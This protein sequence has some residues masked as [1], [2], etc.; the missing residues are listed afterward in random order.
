VSSRNRLRIRTSNGGVERRDGLD[1][2]LDPA[3]RQE[4]EAPV[5]VAR[6]CDWPRRRPCSSTSTVC[7]DRPLI[8]RCWVQSDGGAGRRA[9]EDDQG[10]EIGPGP[11]GMKLVGT[12]ELDLGWA[13]RAP[14]CQARP[15]GRSTAS[16][17]SAR[18]DTRSTTPSQFPP[19]GGQT[20]YT[21]GRAP[22]ALI[23]S[24]NRPV[25]SSRCAWLSGQ[26]RWPL[27]QD[28][29]VP[30]TLGDR[31]ERLPDRSS[32]PRGCSRRLAT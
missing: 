17:P 25:H 13:P 21:A 11:G 14:A 2:S 20:M 1:E 31:I 3:P 28:H 16:L 5:T 19:A 30:A 8:G 6:R 18:P 32:G 26:G 7:A 4:A 23:F 9:A 12:V 27:L 29:G 15:A 22:A 24:A 10:S